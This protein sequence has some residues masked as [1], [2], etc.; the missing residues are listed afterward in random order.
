MKKKLKA[1]WIENMIRKI[2]TECDIPGISLA[3]FTSDSTVFQTRY[4]VRVKGSIKA[5]QHS[6]YFHI[7]SNT[8][9]FT[10]T[11]IASLVEAGIINWDTKPGDLFID[12]AEEIHP[13]YKDITITN[14]LNHT[15]GIQPFTDEMELNDIPAYAVPPK[16][17][18]YLF[19][20]LILK[21]KPFFEP[22]KKVN[23]SNA[24]YSIAASMVETATDKPWKTLIDELIFKKLDLNGMFGWPNNMSPEEPWGHGYEIPDN[25]RWE[26][27]TLGELVC[28]GPDHKYHIH[29]L[30]AP[31]GDIQLTLADFI[32]FCQLHLKGLRGESTFLQPATVKVLHTDYEGY[33]LGWG[34]VRFGDKIISSHSGCAGT[35]FSSALLYPDRSSG[36]VLLANAGHAKAAEGCT[37]LVQWLFDEFLK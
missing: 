6:D 1:K 32:R 7:G 30:L 8:K 25:K 17:E 33:G 22:R 5:I 3:F 34:I 12:F 26:E 21:Q 20:Q 10:S 15:A 9:A 24:G 27:I 11:M 37:K 36:L 2:S 23:Y 16:I 19:S 14:L 4:G 13:D 28:F 35:F 31:A 18:R 29:P